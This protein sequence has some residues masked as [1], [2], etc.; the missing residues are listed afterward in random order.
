VPVQ[1]RADAWRPSALAL[2]GLAALALPAAP[3]A[4]QASDKLSAFVE[5]RVTHDDNVFRLSKDANASAV[6]GSPSRA[7]TLFTTSAGLNLDLPISRQRLLGSLTLSHTH[8]D[9]FSNL[10]FDGHDLR[11]A[12]QWQAGDS[13]RGE[14]GYSDVSA[15]ASFAYLAG[16]APDRIGLRQA[17]ASGAWML[18]PYLRLKSGVTRLEQSNSD[19]A[20]QVNDAEITGADASASFV[21]R[22]GNSIGIGVRAEEGRFPRLQPVGATLVD[23]AYRQVGAGFFGEWASGGGTTRLSARAE[24]VERR[25]EQLPQRDFDGLVGRAELS[26]HPPGKASLSLVAQRDISPYEYVRS[27]LVLVEGAALRPVLR[28]TERLELSASLDYARREYHGDP[29]QALGLAAGRVDHV[30]GASALLAWR[31]AR[32]LLLQLSAMHEQRR[33]NIPLGDYVVNVVAVSGRF[34]F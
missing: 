5:E 6:V 3:A 2:A 9:R 31:P 23:N 10:D 19:P 24:Q 30:H 11:T 25:Y 17:Y 28:L 29:A 27:S 1:S 33:A 21:S 8:Y 18:N 15:L 4:G 14:L 34:T 7:D 32:S 22:A 13:A 20:R 16:T 12:W 26:W